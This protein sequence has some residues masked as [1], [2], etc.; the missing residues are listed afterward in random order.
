MPLNRTI[1]KVVR[2]VVKDIVTICDEIVDDVQKRAAEAACLDYDHA[3][4]NSTLSC[5]D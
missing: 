5:E 2:V 3:V 1:E 4:V